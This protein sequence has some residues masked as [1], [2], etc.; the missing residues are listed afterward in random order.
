MAIAT[1]ENK[2][3]KSHVTVSWSSARAANR[4]VVRDEEQIGRV[5]ADHDAGCGRCGS[6]RCGACSA[7][8]R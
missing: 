4:Q 7:T 8:S 3:K 2:T 5:D 6:R 1:S